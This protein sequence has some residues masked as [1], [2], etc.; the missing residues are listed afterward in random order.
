MPAGL[1]TSVIAETVP[2]TDAWTLAETKPSALP[3]S[4][5]TKTGSPFCTQATA[6][7]PMCCDSSRVT[8]FGCRSSEVTQSAVFFQCGTAVLGTLLL[9]KIPKLISPLNRASRGA[10]PIFVYN[11]AREWR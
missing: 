3:T 5:P 11:A 9:L 6:G 8:C 10:R 7:L 4:V 1:T 2:L